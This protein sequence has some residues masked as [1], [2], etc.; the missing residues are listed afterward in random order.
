MEKTD[1]ELKVKK[2]DIEKEGKV[3]RTVYYYPISEIRKIF[4]F[5]VKEV[6]EKTYGI[7][8]KQYFK[9]EPLVVNGI[10]YLRGELC[11]MGTSDPLVEIVL[12]LPIEDA[13]T[14][15]KEGKYSKSVSNE[16]AKVITR[17]EKRAKI[18]ILG[19]EDP[20]EVA[21]EIEDIE[22]NVKEQD[23][24]PITVAQLKALQRI[25]DPSIIEFIKSTFG[26]EKLEDLTK[27]EAGKVFDYLNEKIA[28]KN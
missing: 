15:D 8:I 13:F 22:K 26:K 27:I 21:G 28:K 4:N 10:T 23:E 17:I 16:A 5:Y 25:K 14:I 9:V 19:L 20:E 6:L 2:Y 12:S 24:A 18:M 11:L 1:Q 3:V 7:P